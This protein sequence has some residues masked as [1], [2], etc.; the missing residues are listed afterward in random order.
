MDKLSDELLS[1]IFGRLNLSVLIG[2]RMIS[3]RFK[4]II[5]QIKID[6]LVVMENEFDGKKKRWF[7]TNDLIRYE[8]A[9]KL[10]TFQKLNTIFNFNQNLRRL[11]IVRFSNRI[12]NFNLSSLNNCLNLVQLEID[13]S[14]IDSDQYL[15]SFSLKSLEVKGNLRNLFLNTPNLL[16]IKTTCLPEIQLDQYNSVKQLNLKSTDEVKSEIKKFENLESLHFDLVFGLPDK[17]ILLDLKNLKQ[18][19]YGASENRI[20]EK[21]KTSIRHI[22][23]Q[24]KILKRTDFKLCFQNVQLV[25]GREFDEYN[26][27]SNFLNGNMKFQFENYSLL[28]DIYSQHL[29]NYTDLINLTH[30]LRM[31]IPDNFFSKFHNIETIETNGLIIDQ[32][33]FIWF[34]N[35]LP[36]LNKL[37]LKNSKLNQAF[38]KQL[39]AELNLIEFRLLEVDSSYQIDLNFILKFKFLKLFESNLQSNNPFDLAIRSCIRL[40][41]LQ[42]FLFQNLRISI[43]NR[44]DNFDLNISDRQI[45]NL[46]LNQLVEQL[47]KEKNNV[48]SVSK[49]LVIKELIKF[50][51]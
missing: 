21:F 3:K 13:F 44:N 38:F 11:N 32:D 45:S 43:L 36:L 6:E 1:R 39:P 46:N 37:N 12:P 27:D 19:S 2:F 40:K 30:D 50:C 35:N 28:G 7:H 15:T 51:D 29:I 31:Q 34:L 18:L 22:I 5:D 10:N 23:K 25:D 48:H 20:D 17:D 4:S 16:R 9:I 41:H 24:S 14:L 47:I 42:N 26:F 8:D 49:E 33:H